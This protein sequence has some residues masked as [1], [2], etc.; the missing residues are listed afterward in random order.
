MPGLEP[1]VLKHLALDEEE[2]VNTDS[3]DL[4]QLHEVSIL[5]LHYHSPPSLQEQ[6]QE[7]LKHWCI[8][9]FL[10]QKDLNKYAAV[11]LIIVE[12]PKHLS[13]EITE[14]DGF[15]Y[16]SHISPLAST[17]PLCISSFHHFKRPQ[18]SCLLTS[19]EKLCQQNC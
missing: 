15:Y 3:L 7:Q 18:P 13:N 19:L 5:S 11:H 10:V 2:S 12:Y 9:L 14:G 17:F 8:Y 6:S 1:H 16:P 4:I